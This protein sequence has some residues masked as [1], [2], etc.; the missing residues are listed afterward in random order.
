M[1][2]SSGKRTKRSNSREREPDLEGCQSPNGRTLA[3]LARPISVSL[4][5]ESC[6]G[7]ML[8]RHRAQ[9]DRASKMLRPQ[10]ADKNRLPRSQRHQLPCLLPPLA[11]ADSALTLPVASNLVPDEPNDLGFLAPAPPAQSPRDQP[12]IV[13][14][15]VPQPRDLGC[16]RPH[17]SIP[18]VLDPSQRAHVLPGSQAQSSTGD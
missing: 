16:G 6:L 15:G 2:A 12:E 1:H 17:T 10:V 9:P 11:A 4:L 8:T 5:F 18:W 14:P 13:S 3:G 7:T